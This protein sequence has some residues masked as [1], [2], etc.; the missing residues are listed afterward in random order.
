[1]KT[2]IPSRPDGPREARAFTLIEIMI[3]MA[4]LGV[5]ITAIYSSWTA[6]LRA[7]D[8]GR[9]AAAEVQ[10]T[11]IAART[12][13]D[14]LAAAVQF[15]GNNYYYTFDADTSDPAATMLSFVARLPASFPGS[16]MY[17]NQPLRRVTFMVEAGDDGGQLV[18]TQT[19][20]LE[21]VTSETPYSIILARGLSE[22]VVDFWETNLNDWASEWIL[23]NQL[24]K[25]VRVQ[26]AY[27]GPN[28]GVSSVSAN[29]I[30]LA[31]G[32]VRTDD[33]MPQATAGAA[34][35]GGRGGQ[36]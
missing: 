10:R 8:A 25:L 33:Q 16:G 24:P 5:I 6:I 30:A 32:T 9:R 18:M 35:G 29:V 19:P 34:G 12:V 17:P 14:A 3:A 36:G 21:E 22:F 28:G 15:E 31:G 7:S 26:M 13:S 2:A 20:V 4:I 1:M 11:R 27:A 23:T